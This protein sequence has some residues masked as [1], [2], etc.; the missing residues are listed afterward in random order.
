M[1]AQFGPGRNF[2]HNDLNVLLKVKMENHSR[3]PVCQWPAAQLSS[4]E[5]KLRTAV[6]VQNISRDAVA[7]NIGLSIWMKDS[8]MFFHSIPLII[9]MVLFSVVVAGRKSCNI[10][11][12]YMTSHQSL[13][14]WS[15]SDYIFHCCSF[16][17]CCLPVS[18]HPLPNIPP[19][20]LGS[21]DQWP[22]P[23][24]CLAATTSVTEMGAQILSE[25][26]DPPTPLLISV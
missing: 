4:H 7:Q 15:H 9:S 11:N 8:R 21:A 23:T 1:A 25:S 12:C 10:N 20:D 22:F 5:S 6:L 24:A 26:Y 17:Q 18:T 2:C 13:R 16:P 3:L 19:F 14:S